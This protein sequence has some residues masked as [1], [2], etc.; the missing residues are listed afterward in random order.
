[1]ISLYAFFPLPPNKQSLSAALQGASLPAHPAPSK[2]L[3]HQNRGKPL[4]IKQTGNIPACLETQL[5]R[6]WRKKKIKINKRPKV[7]EYSLAKV[8]TALLS[9]QQSKVLSWKMSAYSAL[10]RFYLNTI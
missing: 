10:I 8:C 6:M 4:A 2:E 5:N 7:P 9:S 1:M 3:Q